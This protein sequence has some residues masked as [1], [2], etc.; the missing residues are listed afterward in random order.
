VLGAF[1]EPDGNLHVSR[2]RE[3][4]RLLEEILRN[5]KQ[6]NVPVIYCDPVGTAQDICKILAD[7]SI[8]TAV[9]SSIHRVNR[10]YESCGV[11]IGHHSLWSR[12]TNHKKVL[13]MPISSR[14]RPLGQ[15]ILK[16]RNQ[17]FVGRSPP[18]NFNG[19]CFQVECRSYQ[20]PYARDIISKVR[21]RQVYVYGPF[22]K[23]M[24]KIL[25]TTT[26]EVEPLFPNAQPTLF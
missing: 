16:D 21:P 8:A 18:S 25:S 5:L 17:L 19:A 6:E 4:D 9:H 10:I 1:E 24:A 12:R 13:L 23:A 26:K 2:K 3:L 22:A 11:Q 20:T 15:E 7:H 14:I